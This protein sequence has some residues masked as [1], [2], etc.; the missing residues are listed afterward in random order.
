MNKKYARIDWTQLKPQPVIGVD[1]V[2]RG[3]LAGPVFSSAVLYLPKKH[4]PVSMSLLAQDLPDS[5]QLSPEKRISLSQTIRSQHVHA[6]GTSSVPEIEDLNIG[7]ASLLSMKRAVMECYA[8][9]QGKLVGQKVHILVDGN[10]LISN[11]PAYFHQTAFIKGD[12]RLSPI[13]A[14][15]IVAKVAR[16]EWISHQDP[17]YP[18][19]GFAR[20]K[21]YATPQHIQALS[22]YGPCP[23]HRKTF[24]LNY[25]GG[26]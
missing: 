15:S 1:E 8:K 14:A 9:W 11:L 22:Q 26:T 7:Q 3:C 17:K 4:S 21:G 16:D 19:Y 6:I 2:G 13:A 12:Q 24:R 25:T 20:H 10:S 5:K 18:Q 23:L